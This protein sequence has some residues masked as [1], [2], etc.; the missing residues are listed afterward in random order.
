MTVIELK[1]EI[2]D[3]VAAQEQLKAQFEQLDRMKQGKLQELQQLL[4]PDNEKTVAD[5]D[6]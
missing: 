4:L 6:A 1:A 2:F 5:K 3:I